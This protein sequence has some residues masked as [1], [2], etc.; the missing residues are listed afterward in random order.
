MRDRGDRSGTAKMS[1]GQRLAPAAAN[2]TRYPQAHQKRAVDRLLAQVYY[3]F[4]QSHGLI[5]DADEQ[6]T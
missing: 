3:E 4:L 1:R 5:V 6:V 2:K